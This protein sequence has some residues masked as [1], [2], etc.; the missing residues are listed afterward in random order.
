M[1]MSLETRGQEV[2]WEDRQIV[3]FFSPNTAAIVTSQ[4]FLNMK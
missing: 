2:E 4:V 1:R 3:T